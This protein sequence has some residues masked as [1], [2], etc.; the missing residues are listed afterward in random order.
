MEVLAEMKKTLHISQTGQVAQ[1]RQEAGRFQDT[2]TLSVML[3]GVESRMRDDMSSI[4][5][6]RL[7]EPRGNRTDGG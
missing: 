4:R 6:T 3:V 1:G 7:V 2:C 5:T